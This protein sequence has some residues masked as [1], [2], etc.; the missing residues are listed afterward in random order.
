[1]YA[2]SAAALRDTRSASCR[3]DRMV[4]WF[5]GFVCPARAFALPGI[6]LPVKF[7]ALVTSQ[8]NAPMRPHFVGGGR[9]DYQRGRKAGWD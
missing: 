1:M 9:T 4:R 3:N 8:G 5:G 7:V 6:P 2:R